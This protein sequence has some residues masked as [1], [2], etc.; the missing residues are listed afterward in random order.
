MSGG[1]KGAKRPLR[2]PLDGR[3]RPQH[4]GLAK[5]RRIQAPQ[6]QGKCG[7]EAYPCEI[8]HQQQCGKSVRGPELEDG[9]RDEQP[10]HED[11]GHGQGAGMQ[12]EEQPGP[13]RVGEK[14]GDEE[15]QRDRGTFEASFP[16]YQPGGYRHAEVEHRPDGAEQPRGRS[17]TWL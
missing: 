4:A 2:R 17:P 6:R 12:H 11:L 16:P 9:C 14:L 5:N 13:E 3:V 7:G 1:A 10:E 15:R 8:R